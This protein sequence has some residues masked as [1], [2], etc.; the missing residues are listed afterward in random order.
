MYFETNIKRD[1]D[2]SL[3]LHIAGNVHTHIHT[4]SYI[5]HVC[6]RV[7]L[8]TCTS[9][10]PVRTRVLAQEAFFDAFF[11]ASTQ[12]QYRSRLV[13]DSKIIPLAQKSA[14]YKVRAIVTI[15][16]SMTKMQG[17]APK[18]IK[19]LMFAFNLLFVV[20][21]KCMQPDDQVRRRVPSGTMRWHASIAA[22]SY[23]TVFIDNINVCILAR[24][25]K[26][27]NNHIRA[28]WMLIKI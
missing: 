8:G 28:L 21:I 15:R 11:V 7:S 3:F 10:P 9:A 19:F 20:R 4:R 1:L 16:T 14:I 23:R 24:S 2:R 18:T 22:A 27:D 25:L 12:S 5:T 13:F 6:V 17:L 26:I